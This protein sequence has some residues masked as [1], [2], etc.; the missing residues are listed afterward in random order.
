LISEKKSWRTTAIVLTLVSLFIG[1]L[2]RSRYMFLDP[3]FEICVFHLP[4]VLSIIIYSWL[5]E[6]SGG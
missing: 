1:L 3:K 2:Q 6:N 4:A 5:P